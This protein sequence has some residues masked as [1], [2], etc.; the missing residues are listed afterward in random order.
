MEHVSRALQIEIMNKRSLLEKEISTKKQYIRQQ[1]EELSAL[2]S[3]RNSEINALI[4]AHNSIFPNAALSLTQE[5]S[6]EASTSSIPSELPVQPPSPKKPVSPINSPKSSTTPSTFVPQKPGTEHPLDNISKIIA[7]STPDKYYVVF[8]G[9]MAGIYESWPETAKIVNG[10]KGAIHK[11]FKTKDEAVTEYESFIRQPANSYA[12][13]LKSPSFGRTQ[14]IGV[15]KTIQPPATQAKKEI[16]D[17][18]I[19]TIQSYSTDPAK[20]NLQGWYPTFRFKEIPKVIC[21][22]YIDPNLVF[23]FFTHGLVDSIYFKEASLFREFPQTVQK[24]VQEFI[25]TVLWSDKESTFLSREGFWRITNSLPI[26]TEGQ[27][28]LPALSSVT[29]GI[30]SQEY[31]QK[32]ATG[33]LDYTQLTE[34]NTN[35]MIRVYS[36][37]GY[38]KFQDP[39]RLSYKSNTLIILSIGKSPLRKNEWNAIEHFEDYFLA[40]DLKMPNVPQELR[41]VLCKKMNNTSNKHNCQFCPPAEEA[42]INTEE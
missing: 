19:N 32:D 2:I 12:A 40:P 3:L 37:T 17:H 7:D 27:M 9:P 14:P 33:Q 28:V 8:N 25:N 41:Q 35:A 6:V 24:T 39:C 1:E 4:T 18:L 22:P 16:F 34:Y 15:V 31:P 29:M 23:E 36:T 38:M 21:M 5:D 20:C 13:K 26:F 11:S 30:S 42:K 10:M